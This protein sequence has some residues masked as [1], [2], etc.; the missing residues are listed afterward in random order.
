MVWIDT[1]TIV[2]HVVDLFL[3]RNESILVGKSNNVNGYGLTVKTHTEVSTTSTISRM[4]ASPDMTW[5]WHTIDLESHVDDRDVG[6]DFLPNISS[7]AHG[8]ELSQDH[9]LTFEHTSRLA[10]SVDLGHGVEVSE[11]ENSRSPF[12]ISTP[13]GRM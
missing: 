5:T 8:S 12:L 13:S 3:A 7:S 6:R 11:L 10:A 4:G 1:H 2:A 9:T